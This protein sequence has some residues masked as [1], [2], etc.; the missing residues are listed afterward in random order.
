MERNEG[1]PPVSGVGFGMA[2][3]MDPQRRIVGSKGVNRGDGLGDLGLA[4]FPKIRVRIGA[5]LIV[6]VRKRPPVESAL[7]DAVQFT[8]GIVV[9]EQIAPV[10]G[11]KENIRTRLP[12]ETCRIAEPAGINRLSRSVGLIP[13]HRGTAPVLF[14]TNV[15]TRSHCQVETTVG[16]EA[17]SPAPVV[18][19]LRNIFDNADR[20]TSDRDR[21][22]PGLYKG[23]TH[24][25]TGLGDVEPIVVEIDSGG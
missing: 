25:G 18:S 10:V 8:T 3:E 6:R 4:T 16:A 9:P 11:G 21:I 12:V 20:V 15:T 1:G 23:H 17:Q 19:A 22:A 13:E 24:D 5:P 14:L 7:L 2:N